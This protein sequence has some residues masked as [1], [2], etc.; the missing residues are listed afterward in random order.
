MLVQFLQRMQETATLKIELDQARQSNRS[1]QEQAQLTQ[2]EKLKLRD[3]LTVL[4]E[5]ARRDQEHIM[6]MAALV[7]NQTSLQATLEQMKDG[8]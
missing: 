5:S 4:Q 7:A 1:T 2:E 6:S 3:Q 8:K